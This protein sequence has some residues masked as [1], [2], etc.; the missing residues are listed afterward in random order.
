M[1]ARN[2]GFFQDAINIAEDWLM[3]SEWERVP[4]LAPELHDVLAELYSRKG[5]MVNGTRYGRMALDGW[6]KFGSVDDD[7]LEL[8]R[9]FLRD[10]QQVASKKR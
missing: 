10:L 9:V 8:A 5:D 7:Q 1:D 6:I 4:P 3:V 2:N